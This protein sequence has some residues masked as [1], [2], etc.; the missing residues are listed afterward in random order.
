MKYIDE[1]R[2]KNLAKKLV[3]RIKGIFLDE[4]INFMEVCG[5]HTQSF[6]RFGLDGL[7]PENIRL[8]SGPG[9]PVC[10]SP[11]GYMDAAIE[12]SRNK[13]V[14]ITTFG[15]MLRIPGTHSSLEKERAKGANIRMVYSAYESLKIALNNPDKQIVF[16]AVGFETTA[17]TIALSIIAAQKAKVRNLS[18]FSS[19][20]LIPPAMAYL[21]KD[22][23]LNLSGFMC[24]GHVSSIIGTKPYEFIAKRYKIPCCVAGFEP[25]DMLEAIYLLLK[26]VISQRPKVANQ[27]LRVVRKQGNLKAKRII[28]DVFGISDALWRGLGRIPDSGLKIREQFSHLDTEKVFSIDYKRYPISN[29]QK[30]CKCGEILKGL[31]SPLDC[32]LFKK[33][34]SPDN[35]I[36]P[37]M[38]STEGACN[39]YYKYH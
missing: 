3:S 4:K 15:D 28:S 21:L 25:L 14:I 26:Q 32:P 33:A 39:A 11:Q 17:P 9:C 20:K 34:C 30:K 23:R 1:F 35:P 16:L 8:I 31:N 24:P 38:V 18:F 29:K 22:G 2:N 27:Y 13:H 6:H 37:C 19:L 10:V 7:L 12:L 36:G 5:T